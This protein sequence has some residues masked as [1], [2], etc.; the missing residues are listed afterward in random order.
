[1]AVVSEMVLPDS[2]DVEALARAAESHLLSAISANLGLLLRAERE[3]RAFLPAFNAVIDLRGAARKLRPLV[4]DVMRPL[5]NT[6]DALDNVAS[7][8]GEPGQDI[9]ARA[10]KIGDQVLFA[11]GQM[12]DACDQRDPNPN[13]A[14]RRRA[15]KRGPF[16]HQ[17]KVPIVRPRPKPKR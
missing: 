5:R 16:A 8:G 14:A 4:V 12:L 1:M 10:V 13:R 7:M 17:P 9:A 6:R 11:Y 2:A 15:K 3:A